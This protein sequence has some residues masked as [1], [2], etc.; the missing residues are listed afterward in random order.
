MNRAHPVPSVYDPDM[1]LHQKEVIVRQ[2]CLAMAAHRKISYMTIR[3]ELMNRLNVDIN[4]LD[5][6]P[7]SLFLLYEYLFE[8]RPVS[9]KK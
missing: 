5:G 1:S 9:C 8:L 3:D 2:L 7:V 6:D 4:R